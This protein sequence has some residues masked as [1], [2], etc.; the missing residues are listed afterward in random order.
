MRFLF[1]P[2]LRLK[3]GVTIRTLE[4]AAA[5]VRSRVQVRVPLRRANILRR[6]ETAAREAQQ[7]EAASAFRRWAEAEGLLEVDAPRIPD[8]HPSEPFSRP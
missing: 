7:R 6:L 4:Q 8:D 5:F 2:P 1:Q 3:R